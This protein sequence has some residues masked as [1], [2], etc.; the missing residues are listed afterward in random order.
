MMDNKAIGDSIL[1]NTIFPY[2]IKFDTNAFL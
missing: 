2:H 1:L